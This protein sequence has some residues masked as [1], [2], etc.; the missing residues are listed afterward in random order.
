MISEDSAEYFKD[1]INHATEYVSISDDP[2]S[3]GMQVLFVVITLL[4]YMGGIAMLWYMRQ[5]F[6]EGEEHNKTY[7]RNKEKI[8]AN[9]IATAYFSERAHQLAFVGGMSAFSGIMMLVFAISFTI[10]LVYFYA[11]EYVGYA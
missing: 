7:E 1:I 6:K 11:T 2:P 4:L 5:N 9:K 10:F 8:D 3:L